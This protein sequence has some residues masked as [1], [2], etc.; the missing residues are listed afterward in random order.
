MLATQ[1]CFAGLFAAFGAITG[2]IHWRD[3]WPAGTRFGFGVARAFDRIRGVDHTPTV[4][5]ALTGGADGALFGLV[6]GTA[7]GLVVGW[8]VPAEW[9][10]LR[11]ILLAAV[12]LAGCAVAFGMFAGM[13]TALGTRA[14]VGLFAGGVGGALLGFWLY[15][16]DGLMVGAVAGAAVGAALSPRRGRP[17]DL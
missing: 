9:E 10:S 6:V 2:A 1:A 15:R 12:A 16:L 8:R 3:G 13:M 5:G 14:V 7:V 17:P 11:P 4:H